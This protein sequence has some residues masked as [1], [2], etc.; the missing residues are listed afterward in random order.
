MSWP[1]QKRSGI[2]FFRYPQGESVL[3][4]RDRT[5]DM[6]SMLIRE[7]SG[8]HVWLVTHHLTILSYRANMERLSPQEFIRL[9]E[10]EK[11]VNCG[12]TRYVG[13]PT[14]G[15]NGKLILDCY[16]RKFY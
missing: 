9:D 11:P 16:S 10:H 7:C 12:I 15:R 1:R 2:F 13:K 8:L 14:E 5:R 3:D 6:N 4:V